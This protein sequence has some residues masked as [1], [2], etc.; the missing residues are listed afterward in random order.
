MFAA[1]RL[2]EGVARE[3]MSEGIPVDALRVRDYEAGPARGI[4]P[5]RRVGHRAAREG[6]RVREKEFR[7][8]HRRGAEHRRLRRKQASDAPADQLLD[9]GGQW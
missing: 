9:V 4:E 2:V 7:T 8:E 3:C 5:V 1:E 6:G